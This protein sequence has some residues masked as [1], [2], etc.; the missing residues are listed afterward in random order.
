M[1]ACRGLFTIAQESS[2]IQDTF[3][4]TTAWTRG[5]VWVNGHNLGRFWTSAGPQQTLYVPKS[6]LLSGTN[7]LVVLELDHSPDTR[8]LEFVAAPEFSRVA[9]FG[10]KQ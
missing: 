6:F 8:R 5:M 3:L 4:L 10:E 9:N 2:S 1:Y 7:E